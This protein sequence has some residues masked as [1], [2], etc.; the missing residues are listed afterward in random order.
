[1]ASDPHSEDRQS[2]RLFV[3]E[4]T[5]NDAKIFFGRPMNP[6]ERENLMGFPAGYVDIA[7]ESCI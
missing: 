3:Y 2:L 4:K 5:G 6:R 1:M 7:G